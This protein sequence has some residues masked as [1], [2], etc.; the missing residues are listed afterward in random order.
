MRP[1]YSTND[2]SSS[3]VDIISFDSE[4]HLEG[5]IRSIMNVRVSDPS[6]PPPHDADNSYESMGTWLMEED[7]FIRTIAMV[8]GEVAGHISLT[9]A[10]PYLKNHLSQSEY[11]AKRPN[12]FLE[13]S[14]FFVD[15]SLQ[16]H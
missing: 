9:P 5:A 10:H 11:V 15:P 12:G 4:Q 8:D 1:D 14:K 13:I 16:K 7:P 6:Y 3:N 2:T